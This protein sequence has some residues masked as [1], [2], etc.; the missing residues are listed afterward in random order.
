MN[1]VSLVNSQYKLKGRDLKMSKT[2]SDSLR[3][4]LFL[5]KNQA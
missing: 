3:E 2:G 4:A 5:I 1:A